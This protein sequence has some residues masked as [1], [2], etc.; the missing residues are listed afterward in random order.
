[1]DRFIQLF[2]AN[3]DLIN[4]SLS[5]AIAIITGSFFLYS[6]FSD[7]G[8][9]VARSFSLLLLFVTITYIGDLGV[10][11]S[12]AASAESW[13]RFQ[14]LGIA[15]VPAAYLH[16][17]H[18]ILEMTG[19]PSRGRRRS[20]VSLSYVVA[21]IFLVM[22][23]L[24]PWVVSTLATEPAPHFQPGSLFWVFFA[25]FSGA[26]ALSFWFIIRAWRRTM[27]MSNRRRL[28]YLLV[29]WVAPGLSVFPFLLI[30]GR[31][32]TSPTIFYGILIIVDSMLAVMLA[33]MAYSLAFVGN[34]LPD[35]L[36]KARMLQ[37]FL[38]GPV[39]A[40]VT[41]GV[42]VWMPRA[43]NFLGLP[44]DEIMPIAAVMVILFLQWVITLIMP[45]LE[46]WLVYSGEAEI[47]RIQQVEQRL[48][49]GTDFKQLLDTILATVCEIMRVDSA[50]VVS[51]T[52]GRATLERAVGLAD[53][54]LF[55]PASIEGLTAD[56]D[57]SDHVKLEEISTFD[58]MLTWGGYLMLPLHHQLPS[59]DEPRFLGLLGVR[60][61]DDQQG[62]YRLEQ[63]M[64]LATRTAEALEDRRL[65]AEVMAALEGLLPQIEVIQQR[66]GDSVTDLSRP[67]S[68]VVSSPAFATTIKDAL[69]HYWGGPNLTEPALLQ[70][71]VVQ[72][73]LEENDQNAQR[74][75]RAVLNNAIE[76]L[77]PEGQRSMTTAEWILY[78][79][80]EMRFVQG[81]KVRDVA[82][83]LAMSEADFYRKQRVAIEAV[84]EIIADMEL[85]TGEK[86]I[87][88]EEG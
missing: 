8:N 72:R 74:A 51:V 26:S 7:F 64:A 3:A 63:L 16:L 67:A 11:Y 80:L 75:V 86:E 49:T 56:T 59:E 25:Y 4:Q 1:M 15:W 30:S 54:T 2:V 35:R 18:A 5:A 83:R 17:S 29:V 28:A 10:A 57:I 41:L 19:T 69:S 85:S 39:V 13:L 37:F 23:L 87:H 32:L 82:L 79:I 77:R 65:Q 42:I 9:R 38:R 71:T 73:A 84:T 47:R 22:V 6:L 40:I 24:T 66:R 45:W 52:A 76:N 50:F 34:L 60:Q 27:L 62:K 43:G 55:N 46:R 88:Q 81:R 33:I 70:L 48:L 12:S 61:P 20:T 68:E 36:I 58:D 14:W 21:A 44:G 78:N 53:L 31:A